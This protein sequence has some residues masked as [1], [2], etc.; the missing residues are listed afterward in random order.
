[1]SHSVMI[2]I[3]VLDLLHG[4]VVHAKKGER[5]HYQP[6]SSKL[7]PSSEP[8]DIVAAYF[9]LFP[10][11]IM[12]VADL[13]AIQDKGNHY[14]WL[15]SLAEKYPDCQFWLDAGIKALR[16]RAAIFNKT[17]IVPIIGSESP[18]TQQELDVFIGHYPTAVLSLDFTTGG[19]TNNAFLLHSSRHW[20]DN[21]IVM[22]LSRVGTSRGVDRELLERVKQLAGAHEIYAGGGIADSDDLMRL[23]KYGI[24]GAL[25][26]TALHNGKITR[27]DIEALAST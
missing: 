7:S 21:V 23:N 10:F 17:N 22:M 15:E 4:Q 14:V 1:M 12:Y 27:D 11:P 26:A 13:D 9:K 2:L 19:M 6:V 20:P 8:N 3:P 25:V 18:M 16:E 24:H 5:H